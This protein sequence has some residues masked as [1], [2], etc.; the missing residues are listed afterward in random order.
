M[1][2]S[3]TSALTRVLNLLG[4]DL[5]NNL[6]GAN[7]SNELG[8]WESIPINRLNDRI[9]DSAGSHWQD[10]AEFNKGW[11]HSPKAMSFQEE[12]INLLQEE[13]MG[14]KLFA[15]KDPRICRLAPFWLNVL[16]KMNIQPLIVFCHRNP[17][18]VAASLQKRNG[19]EQPFGHLLWLRYVLDAEQIS[20]NQ[21]RFF[22][23]YDQLIKKWGRLITE[24]Q[25]ALGIHWPRFSDKVAEEIAA[26]LS[27]SHRHHYETPDT[28][29]EN[30]TLSAWLRD[31]FEIF[32]RWVIT[33]ENPND[34]SILD[35]IRNA[36]NEAGPAFSR[37]IS[38]GRR[39]TSKL[40]YFR[41]EFAEIQNKLITIEE[42]SF[43]QRALIQD[44]ESE[45]LKL[46]TEL[47]EKGNQINFLQTGSAILHQQINEQENQID[48]FKRKEII[49]R[50]QIN[51]QEN[52]IDTCKREKIIL[53]QQINEQENQIDTCKRTEITLRRQILEQETQINN[54]QKELNKIEEDGQKIQVQL[55][56]YSL[57]NEALKENNND[58]QKRLLIA[59]D[60]S[61]KLNQKNYKINRLLAAQNEE[62]KVLSTTNTSII[63][64][65]KKLKNQLDSQKQELSYI[66]NKLEKRE[67]EL[68]LKNKELIREK[69]Q[70][71]LMSDTLSWKLTKS[72]RALAKPI[73]KRKKN[74]SDTDNLKAKVRI[75]RR[76]GYLDSNW[77]LAQYKDVAQKKI[78]P[79]LHYL[80]YGAAEGRDP[81]PNFNTNAYCDSCSIVASD[82]NPLIHYMLVGKK[83][84]H[85][86]TSL[87]KTIHTAITYKKKQRKLTPI[88]KK[89]LVKKSRK[90]FEINKYK[91][92]IQQ[93]DLFDK[94]WYLD[95]Y[96]DVAQSNIDPIIHYLYYGAKEGRDP[97]PKFN[98]KAYLKT[99]QDVAENRINPL[100]HYL[101]FGN[102]ESRTIV[103][104]DIKTKEQTDKTKRF[105]P[106]EKAIVPVSFPMIQPQKINWKKQADLKRDKNFV[107]V[108]LE[109]TILGT[110]PSEMCNEN[111]QRKFSPFIESI[112][113][114]CKIQC[115]DVEESLHCY[116]DLIK[117]PIKDYF[118]SKPQTLKYTF[119][120][121]I[122]PQ[123]IIAD[124]AF[125]NDYTLRFRFDNISENT[126]EPLV[127]RFYQYEII[128]TN[129]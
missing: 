125:I 107:T 98:T 34:Y 105:A 46:L 31:S 84:G 30:P 62:I 41:K 38:E 104:S 50:Q 59:T 57:E 72:L 49:L 42:T 33:G 43:E 8:H 106:P 109:G 92:I 2:R 27:H 80:L 17:L 69:I 4:C 76:S 6:L 11:F 89:F 60:E 121:L 102:I 119:T 82:I 91:T 23:S 68:S 115:C 75:I 81:G 25:S 101:L 64:E 122:S 100:I 18:E 61:D 96:Q 90:S 48:T 74:S 128:R 94:A 55:R 113:V 111:F 65:K 44:L 47:T 35:S 10:W 103:P 53:R 36:L 120:N 85:P 14:S 7:T 123:I 118:G 19:L 97:G 83:S 40:K 3:G 20:R 26:F 13:F 86:P 88:F 15:L 70:S 79:A 114:F 73:R 93:T 110:I 51:E 39:S 66:K 71:M 129:H 124:I 87:K 99:Y 45:K 37:L 56:D 117:R 54:L 77:Y 126:D 12:A 29:T 32:N 28:V 95:Q 22:I 58:L 112:I 63:S 1:H 21:P 52:Q 108:E 67:K 24:A 116:D 16:G 9:L 127:V 5:P 78:E